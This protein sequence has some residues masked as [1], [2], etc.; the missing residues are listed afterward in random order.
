MCQC[1]LF[2]FLHIGYCAWR[3]QPNHHRVNSF[4]KKQVG[5]QEIG[6]AERIKKIVG[7]EGD[8]I[9]DTT[10]PDGT[11]RKLMDVSKIHA[12]GWQHQISLEEGIKS[13]VEEV[14]D[15]F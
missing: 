2:K 14:K 11:P 13:V 10:K 6:T 3:F 1:I 4:R 15:M 9:Q 8:I 12:M 5:I 7:Y